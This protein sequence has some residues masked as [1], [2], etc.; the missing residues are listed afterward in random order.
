MQCPCNLTLT[1]GHLLGVDNWSKLYQFFNLSRE[2]E[3]GWSCYLNGRVHILQLLRP[4]WT[5]THGDHPPPLGR[6]GGDGGEVRCCSKAW[7]W[8]VGGRHEGSGGLQDIAVSLSLGLPAHL[9]APRLE[10]LERVWEKAEI[11]RSVS[12]CTLCGENHCYADCWRSGTSNHSAN[13]PALPA[14]RPLRPITIHYIILF[15]HSL[16]SVQFIYSFLGI[17]CYYKDIGITY[18][19][20]NLY[21]PCFIKCY[22]IFVFNTY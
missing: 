7:A 6:K 21:L 5:S 9:P 20:I 1:S 10:G 8:P 12:H 2:T 22:Y 17:Q 13:S 4:P 18:S 14:K 3:A 11:P 16:K 19:I 15:I